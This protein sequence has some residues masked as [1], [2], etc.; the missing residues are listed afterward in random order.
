MSAKIISL[1]T[2][3]VFNVFNLSTDSQYNDTEC[4][5]LLI[6]SGTSTR[7]SRGSDQLKPLQQLDN[8]IQLDNNSTKSASFI[9][10]IGSV[11]LIKSVN[12]DTPLRSITFQILPVNISFLFCLADIN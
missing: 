10:G 5:R 2:V 11:T 4:K 9:F 6:N 1:I 8:S 7:L 12:L 3:P